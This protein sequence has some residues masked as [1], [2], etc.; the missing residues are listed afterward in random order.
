MQLSISGEDAMAAALGTMIERGDDLFPMWDEIGLALDQSTGERFRTSLDPQ[1]RTWPKSDMSRKKTQRT[2]VETHNL[3]RSFSHDA[4][5]SGVR[6]G[7]NVP[8]AAIHQFGFDD[9]ILVSAHDRKVTKLF[10]IELGEER[11]I[12]I[13]M[14]T[15]HMFMPPRPFVGLSAA[16]NAMIEETIVAYLEPAP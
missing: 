5:G 8:Y 9:T 3:E 6:W 1:G 4:S 15:A 10:G 2:L 7:T 11:T 13:P 14:H 12:H 16:D